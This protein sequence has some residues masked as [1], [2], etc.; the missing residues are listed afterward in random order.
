MPKYLLPDIQEIRAVKSTKEIRYI[1]RAQRISE[2]VL[3]G[4]ISRLKKGVTEI[5]LARFIVFSFKRRGIKALAFEPIVSFGKNT[6]HIH[7][8]PGNSRLKSGDLVMFDF[9]C[10]VNGYCSDMTRTYIFGRPTAKQKK[11][12][13]SVLE[14]QNRALKALAKGEHRAKQVD[15]AARKFLHR[16]FNKKSFTHGLGHGIGTA[17]H[18]WPNFKPY[19]EDLLKP[20]EVMTVEPG[21]YLKGWGGVRIEDMVIIKKRGIK[22][23]TKAPKQLDKIILE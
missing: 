6:A 13:L 4:V 3:Q 2:A 7:H 10:T 9:G 8:E 14:A 16:R 5:S 18:E 22:N 20:G 1:T 12:Y 17:I 11:V 21:I 23:L 15:A 19:S